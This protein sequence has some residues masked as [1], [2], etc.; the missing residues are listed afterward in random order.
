MAIFIS[1]G[2][3]TSSFAYLETDV[4][5]TEYG[6]WG[7]VRERQKQYKDTYLVGMLSLMLVLVGIGVFFFITAGIPWESMQ[8]LLQETLLKYM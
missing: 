4:F 7:M 3:K 8:K 6:V 2:A 5:E 1:C